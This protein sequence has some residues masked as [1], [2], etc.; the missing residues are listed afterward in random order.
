MNTNTTSNK[1]VQ[2]PKSYRLFRSMIDELHM[3]TYRFALQS[4]VS[5]SC[6]SIWKNRGFVPKYS[7][8][9]QIVSTLSELTG[10]PLTV[11]DFYKLDMGSEKG[12]E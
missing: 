8:M 11:D 6:F 1:T 2:P 4:Q 10:K 5:E 9:I 7:R 3:S 12:G